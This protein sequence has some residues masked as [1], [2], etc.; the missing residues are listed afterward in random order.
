MGR[1]KAKKQGKK[2]STSGAPPDRMREGRPGAAA[3]GGTQL[4]DRWRPWLLAGAVGLLVARPLYPSETPA[5]TGDGLPV[6]MLW[7]AVAVVWM[8]G[9]LGRR[10]FTVR[11]GLL[12]GLVVFLVLWHVA[13]A[14]LGASRSH[15]RPAVNM[16]W[17][18]VGLGL[19]F[20]LVR[21]WVAGRKQI[22]AILAVMLALA[23]ALAGYGLFQCIYEFPQTRAVYYADPEKAL[24]EAN[25]YY[26]PGSPERIAFEKRL[27]SREPIATFALTNSLAG[28]LT[29]W[30]VVI[31]GIGLLG[32]G[33]SA[34]WRTRMGLAAG[35]LLITAC[36]LLTKSRSAYLAVLVGLGSLGGW[37]LWFQVRSFRRLSDQAHQSIKIP[38]SPPLADSNQ[39]EDKQS[40]QV[41]SDIPAPQPASPSA[42]SA[43]PPKGKSNSVQKAAMASGLQEK[44]RPP[45]EPIWRR[46]AL[47][48]TVLL[49]VVGLMIAAA[50][51]WGGLDIQVLTEARKSLQYRLEYWQ[52]TWQIIRQEPLLGCGPG[53]FRYAY[54]RFKLPQASEEIADPHNFLLEIW[55]TAGTPAALTMLG[56]LALW[57]I[58]VVR[59]SRPI[60]LAGLRPR[61][62]A[63]CPPNAGQAD[64]PAK[65]LLGAVGGMAVGFWVG[66]WSAAPPSLYFLL[67]GTPL[68]VATVWA[69]WPWVQQASLPP[70]CPILPAYQKSE[71]TDRS[72]GLRWDLPDF[73]PGLLAMAAGA[74]LVNLLGV[75]GISFAGV[76]CSLWLLVALA[77]LC[78]P[79]A[80][81]V[82]DSLTPLPTSSPAGEIPKATSSP[83]TPVPPDSPAEKPG[84]LPAQNPQSQTHQA[85][86]AFYW[87]D[88]LDREYQVPWSGAIGGLVLTMAIFFACHQTAFSP[89]LERQT[90]I[91]QAIRL[92]KTDRH[93]AEKLLQQAAAADPFSAVP[94]EWLAGLAF[95]QWQ[96]RFQQRPSEPA[97]WL[98]RLHHF[99]QYA[100]L[101]LQ[102]NPEDASAWFVQGQRFLQIGYLLVKLP[103]ETARR[104]ASWAFQRALGCLQEAVSL[105]PN[106]ALYRARLAEAFAALDY[107]PGMRRE[108]QAA[109]WLDDL[110]PHSEKKLPEALRHQLTKM[111]ASLDG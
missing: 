106:N 73:L 61:E 83:T 37:W 98:P 5:D 108:A 111:Q 13:S 11:F 104:Q 51:Y 15:A 99:E 91:H 90:L 26:P 67:I 23:V 16:L 75:G 21:Q 7:L 105:Y 52:A 95:Q 100:F 40:A 48:T 22:R 47:G 45:L 25:F 63:S 80:S 93:R 64:A 58:H 43:D 88:W 96:E 109:L 60:A 41:S 46:M 57:A 54:T 19:V 65:L 36:L 72:E 97:Y 44:P 12:D 10:N 6:V 56:F 31:V 14:L 82:L 102:L 92:A 28:F 18:W 29:P 70:G 3:D 81:V 1:K 110:M 35:G 76:A 86:L 34:G 2:L 68:A 94:A 78:P 8:L 27:E 17:E 66:Q 38:P 33:W 84:K 79:S 77:T 50:F 107:Q 87:L 24:R 101:S 55:A 74:L 69:I 85:R 20:L 4:P 32:G 9:V 62:L 59:I 89:V 39:R 53:L 103:Q 71:P 30:L 42:Q 49:L